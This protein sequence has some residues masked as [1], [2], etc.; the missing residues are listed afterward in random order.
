[1]DDPLKLLQAMPILMDLCLYDGYMG[2]QLHIERGGFQKLKKL[3][4][5]SLRGLNR[6]MIDEGALPLLDQLEIGPCI[7]SFL[8]TGIH[9]QKSLKY[10]ELYEMPTEFVLSL[11]P[12]EGA[13]FGKVKHIPSVTFWYRTHEATTKATS[14]AIQNCW[15]VYKVDSW[16]TK[17]PTTLSGNYKYVLTHF[18][19]R[20]LH[21]R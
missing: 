7:D 4:L 2:E 21:L 1:M 20:L 11:Q 10:L 3:R 13:D 17:V 19:V 8:V 12:D 18:S 14:L 16:R 15:S 6:L 5:R 9:H